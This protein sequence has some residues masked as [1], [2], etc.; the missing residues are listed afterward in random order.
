[1]SVNRNWQKKR[2]KQTQSPA[3]HPSDRSFQFHSLARV[4]PSVTRH[5]AKSTCPPGPFLCHQISASSIEAMT[6]TR[7]NQDYSRLLDAWPQI[8]QQDDSGYHVQTAAEPTAKS[9]RARYPFLPLIIV[10]VISNLC[11]CLL[12]GLLARYFHSILDFDRECSWYTS[13]FCMPVSQTWPQS[14]SRDFRF[15]AAKRKA[16]NSAGQPRSSSHFKG[17]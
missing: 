8:E 6:S 14:L 16:I 17:C 11:C 10:F 9:W 1:M 4:D 12:G 7:E 2:P 5:C 3:S 15:P 13:M